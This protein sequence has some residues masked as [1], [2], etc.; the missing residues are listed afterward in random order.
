MT[1]LFE[2]I[3]TILLCFEIELHLKIFGVT[4][5]CLGILVIIITTFLDTRGGEMHFRSFSMTSFFSL[6][7]E[8]T[9]TDV[10]LNGKLNSTVGSPR[11]ETLSIPFVLP[12]SQDKGEQVWWQHW[13]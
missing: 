9:P 10:Y 13:L 7:L 12:L 11:E 6:Y 5:L 1:S 2:N 8:A 4:E 3:K